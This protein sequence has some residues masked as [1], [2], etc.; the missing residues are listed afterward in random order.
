[1]RPGGSPFGRTKIRGT[2]KQPENLH[3]PWTTNRGNSNMAQSHTSGRTAF[4]GA[5]QFDTSLSEPIGGTAIICARAGILIT[6]ATAAA[7]LKV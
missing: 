6:M 2:F 4:Q 7:I 5:G 1:M 3:R